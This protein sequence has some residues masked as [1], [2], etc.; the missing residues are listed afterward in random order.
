M[1]RNSLLGLVLIGAILIGYSYLTAPSAEQ[2]AAQQK[3]QDSIALVEKNKK[4]IVDIKRAEIKVAD[5]NSVVADTL[6]DSLVTQELSNKY[7]V[8]ASAA[9]SDTSV[10]TLEN[11]LIKVNISS[12][13]GK[14]KSVQL[15]N[16]KNWEGKPVT[17]FEGDSSE[18]ALNFFANN[19]SISTKD[20]FFAGI[21]SNNTIAMRLYAGSQDK[22]IE[23]LYTL[24]DDDYKLGYKV[25]FVGLNEIIARNTNYVELSWKQ[26]MKNQEKD[27]S[28]ER[29]NSTIYFMFTDNEVDYLT[30]T[31]DESK[32]LTTKVKWVAMKQH[33]FTQVLIA[34]NE[35]EKPTRVET[36][37]GTEG[38]SFVKST[39]A[40]FTLPYSHNAQESFGM[41]FYFGPNHYQILKSQGNNLEKQIPLG[42]GIFGWVNRFIVI[43]I[44]NFLNGFNWSYG[45]II[46]ILTIA[47]K[48]LLLPLTFKAYL[49][50]AKMKV[51]KPEVDE[52]QGKFKEE[53]MK[54]QQ[55]MMALYRK[56]GVSPLGG[57][58]PM[59]LQMP[60]L[61]AMFRFFPQSIEL[62][63]QS[64]LWA[65]DLSTY[66]SILDLSFTIPFYGDHVSLFTLLMT[67]S[68]LLITKVNSSSQMT[69]PQMKWMMYL[70]PIVF[71]G[72]FN[73]YSAGLSY[74][75]FLANMI[76]IGQQYL[77]RSFVNEDEIH[78]KIQENKKKPTKKSKFQQRLEKMA[79]DRGMQL[80]K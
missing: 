59:L 53:P 41:H 9:T 17:L 50:Q 43:P 55:E 65:T 6:I 56:A 72:V 22:Y 60:I 21:K 78:R 4:T 35:F 76:S 45:I 12:K 15:K 69:N 62:R 58:L 18:M 54:L 27:M 8:F 66:D 38:D 70:M 51:L 5:T 24:K 49:S 40:S 19:R 11:K 20:L 37:N 71:L 26:L 57:C 74:Y 10:Y 36:K 42:W 47:I 77:F 33:F 2:L 64:F 34:D 61:I 44:F 32:D 67:V 79:K 63:Q 23:F 16:Y 31:S 52:I 46:L 68:T 80:P 39:K 28:M 48:I 75:Y 13:G 3:T 1:D 14:V 25:N 29:A 7:G 73:S 30:E